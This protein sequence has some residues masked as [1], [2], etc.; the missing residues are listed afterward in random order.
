MLSEEQRKELI[1]CP[2]L[3][4][5]IEGGRAQ[6]R[7]GSRLEFHSGSTPNNL[8]IL[9]RLFEK[10]KA[11]A[12]LETGLGF[13]ASCALLSACHRATGAAPSLQ[14]V[15]IDPFQTSNWKDAGCVLLEKASLSQY[16]EIVSKTSALHLP[17][18]FAERREFD[19]IYIDGSHLFE[20]VFTDFYY[21]RFLLRKGGVVAFDDCTVP[22]IAKVLRFISSNLRGEFCELDLSS[23]RPN[24]GHSVR[25]KL[26]RLL[27]KV[28]IRAFEKTGG[29]ER[30]IYS[31][32]GNF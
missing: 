19:L 2:Q 10:T 27:G 32:F 24:D 3:V 21:S 12:T 25:Y 6:A 5:M 18:L 16:A 1:I 30:P 29:S 17:A 28:Q 26:A 23:Y 14:H 20:D 13:G 31:A 11:V 22:H 8:V 4:E 9:R 7:D 15:A